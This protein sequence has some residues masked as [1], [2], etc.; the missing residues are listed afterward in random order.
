MSAISSSAL[1][2]LGDAEIGFTRLRM[3]RRQQ[4]AIGGSYGDRADVR[5]AIADRAEELLQLRL[6]PAAI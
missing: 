6:S 1:A 5:Q 2:R 3:A 4:A